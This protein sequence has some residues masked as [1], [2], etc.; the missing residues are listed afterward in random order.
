MYAYSSIVYYNISGHREFEL[1][2]W[3]RRWISFQVFHY[4]NEMGIEI[5]L[6][7]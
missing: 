5:L 2:E 1:S 6:K 7:S 3:N 4:R